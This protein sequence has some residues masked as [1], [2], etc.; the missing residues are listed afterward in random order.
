MTAISQQKTSR[1]VL[2]AVSGLFLVMLLVNGINYSNTLVLTRLLAPSEY[3]AYATFGAL[4]LVLTLL[5]TTLQQVAARF[6]VLDNS[7]ISSVA[8]LGI[9]TGVAVGLVLLVFA[10]WFASVLKLPL[11]WLI[12]LA[13][14]TPVYALLGAF[15]G[16]AQAKNP[17]L[18]GLNLLLEHSSKILITLPLWFVLGN[19]NAP[20]MALLVSI[21]VALFA[22]RPNIHAL[23]FPIPVNLEMRPFVLA[24]LSGMTAQVMINNADVILARA[25]LPADQAGVYAAIAIIGR[26][27]FYASWAVG[28]ALFPK[29]AASVRDQLPHLPLLWRGLSMVAAS[30]VVIAL[31]CVIFPTQLTAILFGSNYQLGAAWLA[32]YAV[33]TSFYALS[34]LISN[35]HMALGQRSFGLLPMFGAVLQISLMLVFHHSALELVLAQVAAMGMLFVLTLS[36]SLYLNFYQ[37]ST[38]VLRSL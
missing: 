38:H 6:S 29:V 14:L 28:T 37:R 13:I 19:A 8:R 34:N 5:P 24:S 32:P 27:V 7:A 3:G 21:A 4:F 36:T 35:H 30:S 11:P 26:V 18:F 1:S 23:L 15:R 10:T 2:G 17:N 25:W 12:G 9:Q 22:L 20:V 31:V 33:A 16:E